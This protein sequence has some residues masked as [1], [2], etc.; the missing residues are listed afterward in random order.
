PATL[1]TVT[2]AAEGATFA[3]DTDFRVS[4]TNAPGAE[5]Y[6]IASFT[7]LLIHTGDR[8]SPKDAA[9][10]GFLAWMLEPTAQRMAA[11]LH[12]APLPVR[13]IELVKERFKAS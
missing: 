4:I 5:T 11:D 13:L 1:K 10:R 3:P 7:W 9:I 2:A 12:Y 6:P 8:R